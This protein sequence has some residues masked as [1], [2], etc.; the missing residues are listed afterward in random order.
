MK[1]I[2]IIGIGSPFGPD[3]LG[4]DVVTQLQ[5]TLAEKTNDYQLNF[6]QCDRPG[7]RLLEFMQDTDMTILV[8]AIEQSQFDHLLKVKPT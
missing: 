3:Q 4:W 2:K 1:R 5:H 8:D 7:L 6:I